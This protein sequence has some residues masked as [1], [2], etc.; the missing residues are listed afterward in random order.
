VGIS[1]SWTR[2]R[3]ASDAAVD[4]TSRSRRT[5]AISAGGYEPRPM[6]DDGPR[7][8]HAKPIRA[9]I[10]PDREAR[11]ER[12]CWGRASVC[13][14]CDSVCAT[15]CSWRCPNTSRQKCDGDQLRS[16]PYSCPLGTRRVS[17]GRCEAVLACRVGSCNRRS[18]LGRRRGLSCERTEHGISG[19]DRCETVKAERVHLALPDA[20]S[21][22]LSPNRHVRGLCHA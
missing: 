7:R 17:Y 5:R 15:G 13:S 18:V 6:I 1:A 2:G 22:R 21:A 4:H 20:G 16:P 11:A 14:P 19:S 10:P 9:L 3:I 8:H 12:I